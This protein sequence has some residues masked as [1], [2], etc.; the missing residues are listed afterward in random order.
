[1]V[2]PTH[3]NRTHLSILIPFVRAIPGMVIILFFKC[4][5]A[6]FDSAHRRG[7]RIKWGLVSYT[8]VVFSFVTVLNAMDLNIFSISYIDN[9]EFPGAKEVGSPGPFGYQLSLAPALNVIPIVMFALCNWL[10]GGLLVG[11]FL[12]FCLLIHMS[13]A[14]PSPSSI[15]VMSYTP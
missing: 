12:M 2:C 9:R 15:V 6:L 13:N 8:V 3:L 4:M 10:A 11:S 5:A 7:E 1:M 14:A